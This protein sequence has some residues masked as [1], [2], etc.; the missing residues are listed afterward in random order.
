MA[1]IKE[2]LASSP[3]TDYP[4]PGN[5]RELRNT[6]ERAVAGAEFVI[7][8]FDNTASLQ[9]YQDFRRMLQQM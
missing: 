3:G 1:W 2:R 8:G 7:D 4:W 9:I 5:V 6:L